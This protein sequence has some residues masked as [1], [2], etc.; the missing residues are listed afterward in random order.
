MFKALLI[1]LLICNKNVNL[2]IIQSHYKSSFMVLLL[3]QKKFNFIIINLFMLLDKVVVQPF[4]INNYFYMVATLLNMIII[5]HFYINLTLI[6]KT[7]FNLIKKVKLQLCQNQV[8]VFSNGEE[9]WFILVECQLIYLV[10]N[11][12]FLIKF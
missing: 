3:L 4:V 5:N 6:K 9:I 7:G 10:K 12:L 8:K 2:F 1:H 11:V